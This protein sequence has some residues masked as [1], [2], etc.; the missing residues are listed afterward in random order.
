[1]FPSA[2]DYSKLYRYRTLTQQRAQHLELDL[3]ADLPVVIARLRAAS[4]P[5]VAVLPGGMWLAIF[6]VLPLFVMVSLSLQTGNLITASEQTFHF[7][8][9]SHVHLPVPRRS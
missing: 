3:R 1:M 8:N 5:Y 2:A 7:A 6:F 9:Y 4:G